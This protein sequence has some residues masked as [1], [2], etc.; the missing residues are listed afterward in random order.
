MSIIDFNTAAPSV[1]YKVDAR[2]GSSNDTVSRQW[3]SRPADQKFL[4]LSDLYASVKARAEAS[5]EEVVWTKKVEFFAPDPLTR[6]THGLKLGL[7]DGTELNPN[8]WSFNQLCS[9]VKAPAS[10]LRSLPSQLVADNLT[11]G[12]RTGG[13]DW[14]KTYASGGDLLAITGQDYGRIFDK[15]VVEA[16]QQIAGNG[17]GDFRWKVPGV[18]DWRTNTYNPHAPVTVDT[19]TLFAS[20]RDVFIFLVDDLNP[21]EI[22]KLPDGSPDLVFRGFYVSNSEVGASSLRLAAF[23]LRAVCCNRILWGV[24]NF[25]ELTLRHTKYAPSRFIEEARPALES[26]ANGST[27][28]LLEGVQKAKEAVVAR[29]QDDAIDFLQARSFSR[30]KAIEILTQGEEEEGRPVRTAWDVAQALTANARN[31]KNNDA[32]LEIELVAKRVLDKVA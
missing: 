24:E 9:L 28:K 29:D 23:Y 13:A 21:I 20:D 11:Y 32:R 2:R 25:Q 17:N 14:R 3:I 26:F 31:E 1:G 7:S 10:Y 18:L 12:Y 4:S 8:H 19:T 27:A 16:V 30:K 6:D 15:E 22:G 5:E